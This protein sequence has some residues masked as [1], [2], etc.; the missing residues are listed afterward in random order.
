MKRRDMA[1]FLMCTGLALINAN[2]QPKE[3]WLWGNVSI[4]L[5][6]DKFEWENTW[7]ALHCL[8]CRSV[9]LV[10]ILNICYQ[11]NNGPRMW[12][13]FCYFAIW[14]LTNVQDPSKQQ[15]LLKIFKRKKKICCY[16]LFSCNCGSDMCCLTFLYFPPM[17]MMDVCV[18]NSP[19]RSKLISALTIQQNHMA[20]LWERC[21]CSFL[22]L[23][24][25]SFC[26]HDPSFHV[27]LSS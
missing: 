13:F 9:N 5:L 17:H 4:H 11:N 1:I 19:S 27:L 3:V 7:N 10:Y 22:L 23:R 8:S 21:F 18:F 14:S 12:T 24:F 6:V 25:I 15:Y 26:V 20:R 2:A 16:M